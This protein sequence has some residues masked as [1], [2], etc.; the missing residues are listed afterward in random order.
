MAGMGTWVCV[1]GLFHSLPEG[2]AGLRLAL[3]SGQG[4][5]LWGVGNADS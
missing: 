1:W 3:V 4:W 5:V 2:W